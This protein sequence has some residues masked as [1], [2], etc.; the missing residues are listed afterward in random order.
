ME[1]LSGRSIKIKANAILRHTLLIG[2]IY[3][4][5]TPNPLPINYHRLFIRKQRCHNLT[6][7]NYQE[8]ALRDYSPVVHIWTKGL[9]CIISLN[10]YFINSNQNALQLSTNFTLNFFNFYVWR[11]LELM[12][13]LV[14]R[15][16]ISTIGLYL[17]HVFY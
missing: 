13:P 8:S 2:Y 11:I 7:I 1:L 3:S 17:S 15:L 10:I 5:R 14:S 4:T 12:P 16:K 6:R 9:A